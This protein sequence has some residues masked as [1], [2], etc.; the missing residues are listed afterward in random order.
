M[1]KPFDP[2][3]F[4]TAPEARGP[5]LALGAVGA[6]SGA[7]TIAT[8]FALTGVVVAIARS[9]DLSTPL[10][11]L[12][13][14]FIARGLLAATTEYVAARA[15]ARV[16]TALRRRLLAAWIQRPGGESDFAHRLTLATAGC[17]S[18]EP[19]VARFLP[20]LIAAAIVPATAILTLL[21]VDWP[22]ALVV[23]ATLPL[24]PLFAALIGR[25]TAQETQH[26]WRTLADL[27]GHFLDVVRGLPT[28]VNFGRAQRQLTTIGDVNERHRLATMRTLRLAFLST[29]A[30]ELLATISVAIVAVLCGVR[31]AHGDMPLETAMLAILLAPE[32]Y[33][34]V[35]RVGQEF[36]SAADGAAALEDLTAELQATLPA[37][38]AGAGSDASATVAGADASAP[39][40]LTDTVGAAA[41]RSTPAPSGTYQV[42][43]SGV[44]YCYP[45]SQVPTLREVSL[46]A[47]P[48]L[49]AITGPSGI[50]KSTLLA[51]VAGLRQPDVGSVAAPAAHLVTQR[52]FLPAGTVTRNLSLGNASGQQAQWDALREVGLD[53]LVAGLPQ[54]LHTALGDD[55]FGL[56]AG[57]R[58]RLA[59]ARALLAPQSVILL[60]EPTAHL[61]PDS[62]AQAHGA[63]ANLAQRRCVLVVTHRPELVA[64]ADTH[65]DLGGAAPSAP[66]RPGRHHVAR[67]DG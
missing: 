49:T 37:T 2:Q 20:A 36:H 12:A 50:G 42:Q 34:P 15:G 44:G 45:G 59:L 8:A 9:A 13:L 6:A 47:G 41:S 52:P 38:T 60:D 24:L 29:G 18:I 61:D 7:A 25:T 56:S 54:G 10:A 1:P 53:G 63:I 66:D 40:A 64:L 11:W 3:L 39:R 23:A 51:L 28:L 35:R 65:I 62:A 32:A 31:L 33:W 5:L 4:R 58:A 46:T 26:R 19:Y 55:G 48:G 27:S 30:L 57:Q 17:S 21:L 67:E 16:S 14:L 22:S 43:V